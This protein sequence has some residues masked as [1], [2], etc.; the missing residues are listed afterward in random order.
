MSFKTLF[1][2]FKSQGADSGTYHLLYPF[3]LILEN[4]HIHSKYL[5]GQLLTV[6]RLKTL[7]SSLFA[8]LVQ[9]TF[10]ITS[11]NCLKYVHQLSPVTGIYTHGGST[12]CVLWVNITVILF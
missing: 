10:C 4:D 2:P 8:C 6:S 11:S 1:K 7:L 9:R 3:R 5:Y 12:G